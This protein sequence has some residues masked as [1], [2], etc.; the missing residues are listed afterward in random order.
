LWP[1]AHDWTT[2]NARPVAAARCGRRSRSSLELRATWLWCSVSDVFSSY[3]TGGVQG[4]H[5]GGLLLAGGSIAGRAPT[6]I[7]PQPSAMVGER[8]KGWLTIRLGQT[9]VARNVEHR[10]RVDGARGGVTHSVAM[11]G[12]NLGFI[13]VIFKILA[14][15]PS[16][17]RGFGL[18]ISCACRALSP[19]SQI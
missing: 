1:L 3:G 10:H 4:T 13:S 2:H 11:K 15:R 19:S 16:I 18:I 14:Q 5:Q 6:R 9:G 7:K 17:Y 8:S 12:V